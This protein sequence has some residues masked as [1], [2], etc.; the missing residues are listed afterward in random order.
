MLIFCNYSAVIGINK[1]M[2]NTQYL[3]RKVKISNLNPIV[4]SEDSDTFGPCHGKTD[5]TPFAYFPEI[6]VTILK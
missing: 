4:L 6:N 5:R 1:A 3:E 2:A